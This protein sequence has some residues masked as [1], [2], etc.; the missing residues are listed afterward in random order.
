MKSRFRGTFDF[1]RGS[2][3]C[4][5]RPPGVISTGLQLAGAGIS[6]GREE[7][8]LWWRGRGAIGVPANAADCTAARSSTQ[9]LQRCPCRA[10]ATLAS[11][12]GPLCPLRLTSVFRAVLHHVLFP[13]LEMWAAWAGKALTAALSCSSSFRLAG[14][15]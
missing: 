4:P 5:E 8:G 7:G 10:G 1:W 6:R 12:P 3:S 15:A 13:S 2:C 14:W 9:L 11:G